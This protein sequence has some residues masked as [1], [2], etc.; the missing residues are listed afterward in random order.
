MKLLS[1]WKNSFSLLVLLIFLEFA[2]FKKERKRNEEGTNVPFEKQE[3][4]RNDCLEKK[5]R[6][7]P[8][9][10]VIST[11][12][13]AHYF[14]NGPGRLCFVLL[15]NFPYF[16]PNPILD[17]P[18]LRSGCK[19]PVDLVQAPCSLLQGLLFWKWAWK[20]VSQDVGK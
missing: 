12:Q 13:S 8:C 16:T 6:P 4:G 15:L 17:A 14:R 18:F 3:R 7:I 5:E 10:L 9:M 1:K 2:I 11:L 19:H 20:A